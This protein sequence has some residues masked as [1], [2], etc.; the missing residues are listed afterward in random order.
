ME[1]D[2]KEDRIEKMVKAGSDESAFFRIRWIPFAF[3]SMGVVW[4]IMDSIEGQTINWRQTIGFVALGIVSLL[5][6]AI[7]GRIVERSKRYT[8]LDDEEKDEKKWKLFY[9]VFFA[10]FA[11]ILIVCSI[12]N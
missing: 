4:P 12:L 10:F 1:N 8:S 11:A 9:G 2:E 3:F 6:Y 7:I 5:I